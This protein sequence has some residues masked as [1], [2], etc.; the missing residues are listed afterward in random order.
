M[1]LYTNE[2]DMVI[3]SKIKPNLK[4]IYDLKIRGLKDKHIASSLGIT[5]K[6]FIEA[7]DLSPELKDVYED[8]MMLLCSKLR[9]VA[10]ERALGMDGKVDKDG[11]P[12][13]ADA[14]LAVRLLEKLDPAFQKK[15]EVE[16]HVTVEHV[17]H[18][19]SEKRREEE[20]K[21][22]AINM[23]HVGGVSQ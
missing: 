2:L 23:K 5:T 16:V 1:K 18:A 22:K 14:N 4:K 11:I 19:I 17:I 15:Q 20:E 6:Q 13:G 9:E 21:R 12:V 3:E 8:A 7:M 10:I